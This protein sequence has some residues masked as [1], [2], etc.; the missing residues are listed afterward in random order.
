MWSAEQQR[1]QTGA[2][3]AVGGDDADTLTETLE[4]AH[5]A[6]L[7][8][9]EI[10]PT[11]VFKGSWRQRCENAGIK[12]GSFDWISKQLV[13]RGKVQFLDSLGTYLPVEK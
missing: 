2:K 7:E 10:Y 13:R 3:N 4:R 1:R 5:K 12:P 11:G 8:L 6:F 9:Y